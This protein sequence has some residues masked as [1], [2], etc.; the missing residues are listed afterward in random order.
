MQL[1]WTHPKTA[2]FLEGF[3]LEF[4]FVWGGYRQFGTRV[5]ADEAAFSCREPP[6]VCIF[7]DFSSEPTSDGGNERAFTRPPE[8]IF[9]REYCR[10][11]LR[12]IVKGA[13]LLFKGAS[14]DPPN[15]EW[16]GLSWD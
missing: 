4:T 3:L 12:S 2:N 16:S 14:K 10:S 5:Y 8:V 15:T 13:I 6:R 1:T 9:S 11:I 7:V